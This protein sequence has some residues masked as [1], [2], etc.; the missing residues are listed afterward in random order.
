DH[1][2][3]ALFLE[4]D[5]NVHDPYHWRALLEAFARD[6]VKYLGRPDLKTS[7]KFFEFALDV[8]LVIRDHSVDETNG[9]AVATALQKNE[10]YKT[11]YAKTNPDTFR[12]DVKAV[13]KLIGPM[14]D[15]PLLRLA[16]LDPDRFTDAVCKY[17]GVTEEDL[18]RW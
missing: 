10:P 7:E 13:T 14:N 17:H 1:K 9:S 16:K 4:Y 8:T 6:H 15:K 18:R 12:K 2:M 11:R 3:G 5:L